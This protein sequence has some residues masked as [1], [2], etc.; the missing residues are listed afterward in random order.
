MSADQVTIQVKYPIAV[1]P[2]EWEAELAPALA[3]QFCTGSH[4]KFYWEEKGRLLFH[5]GLASRVRAHFEQE[6]IPKRIDHQRLYAPEGLLV[7]Q[8]DLELGR[9]CGSPQHPQQSTQRPISLCG[10]RL[11]S[12]DTR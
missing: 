2:V 5:T 1:L 10:R 8:I 9:A 7:S 4:R 6:G 11:M 12:R 3:H